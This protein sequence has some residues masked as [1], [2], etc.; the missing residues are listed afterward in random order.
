MELGNAS[1]IARPK[2]MPLLDGPLVTEVMAIRSQLIDKQSVGSFDRVVDALEEA[3]CCMSD[4]PAWFKTAWG[5]ENREHLVKLVNDFDL[6]L[7]VND[8]RE[9]WRTAS[10]GTAMV[11]IGWWGMLHR[12]EKEKV[13]LQDRATESRGLL[14]AP[15]P[16]YIPAAVMDES[17][18]CPV[19]FKQDAAGMTGVG[20]GNPLHEHRC[21]LCSSDPE[22]VNCAATGL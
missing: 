16:T 19:H 18:V 22:C 2:L 9:L 3:R 17:Y 4:Q 11:W 14:K 20:E 12:M 15:S 13:S 8:L 5:V 7:T 6:F 1:A 21:C 10:L